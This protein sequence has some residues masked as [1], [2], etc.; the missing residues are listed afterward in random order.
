MP[1]QIA[2]VQTDV[3]QFLGT[4][5]SDV[6]VAFHAASVALGDKLGGVSRFRR[7]TKAPFHQI[8]E[9]RP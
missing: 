1:T 8:F 6:A 9:V 7:A 3:E 4:V 5:A 2:D